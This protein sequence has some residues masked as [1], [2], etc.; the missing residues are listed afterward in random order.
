MYLERTQQYK[1]IEVSPEQEKNIS[2]IE[3]IHFALQQSENQGFNFYFNKQ[4]VGFILIRE[5]SPRCFFLWDLIIDRNFQNQGHG[6]AALMILIGHLKEIH[7]GKILTTTYISGNEHAK[8]LYEKLGF[9]EVD[10]V[11]V[12]GIDEVNLRLAL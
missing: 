11:R 1:G 10:T 4:K 7:D 6:T 3:K 9:Q 8:A 12:K 5:F 2:S